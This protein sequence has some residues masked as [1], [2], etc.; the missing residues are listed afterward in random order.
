MSQHTNY[1]ESA[2]N[3]AVHMG[4]GRV[5]VYGH[6]HSG[7]R[8]FLFGVGCEGEPAAIVYCQQYNDEQRRKLGLKLA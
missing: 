7:F 4:D 1:P 3:V 6:E 8:P 5:R 2:M